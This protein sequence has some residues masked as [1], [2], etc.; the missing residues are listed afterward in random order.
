MRLTDDQVE[1]IL[2][3]LGI[4]GDNIQMVGIE[5]T[6]PSQSVFDDI[7]LDEGDLNIGDMS[8]GAF[9]NLPEAEKPRVIT[10]AF[11]E[12]L[13]EWMDDSHEAR[14]MRTMIAACQ[15]ALM[16][17]IDLEEAV[18]EPGIEGKIDARILKVFDLFMRT[19]LV[20]TATIHKITEEKRQK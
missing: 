6:K 17:T 16:G 19:H 18:N 2:R 8:L 13:S 15:T 3:K 9:L 5:I 14:F 1:E 12:Y 11:A 4:E 20:L 10:S 7:E